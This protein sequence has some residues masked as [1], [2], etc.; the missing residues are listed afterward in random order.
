MIFQVVA[1]IQCP[2]LR[3]GLASHDANEIGNTLTGD[4][5]ILNGSYL[6]GDL[7]A[8]RGQTFTKSSIW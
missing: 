5:Q 8:C 4:E 1:A 2:V 6:A 3:A 7:P